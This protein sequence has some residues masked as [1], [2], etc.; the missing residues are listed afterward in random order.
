MQRLLNTSLRSLKIVNYSQALSI[1]EI[2]HLNPSMEEIKS[3]YK[4][5]SMKW[6]PDKNP[7][8]DTSQ[9]FTNIQQAYEYCVSNYKINN[10]YSS[11]KNKMAYSHLD[12]RQMT[13]LEIQ[14]RE[15]LKQNTPVSLK[16]QINPSS[17]GKRR[18]NQS[19]RQ[20]NPDA[21]VVNSYAGG[22]ETDFVKSSNRV[23]VRKRYVPVD[24]QMTG[25]IKE[26]Q[27]WTKRPSTYGTGPGYV[28]KDRNQVN[29]QDP[30]NY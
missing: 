19:A 4:T 30:H 8:E 9:N 13:E 29:K 22:T 12:R 10:Q 6:H 28:R 21:S 23:K 3:A 5:S 1:L 14:H 24:M 18:T 17:F 11:I 7:G 20:S 26:P 16:E 2:T 15:K 27:P 25:G